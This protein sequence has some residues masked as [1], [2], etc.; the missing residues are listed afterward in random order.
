V[1]FAQVQHLVLLRC[2]GLALCNVVFNPVAGVVHER[3]PAGLVKMKMSREPR[4]LPDGT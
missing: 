4:K 2:N 3:E 1:P